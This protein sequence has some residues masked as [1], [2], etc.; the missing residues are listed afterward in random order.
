MRKDLLDIDRNDPLK[1]EYLINPER[2]DK[3]QRIKATF[4]KILSDAGVTVTDKDDTELSCHFGLDK[5]QINY[6][7]NVKN[8]RWITIIKT[9]P[10]VLISEKEAIVLNTITKDN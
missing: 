7:K 8:S 1:K 9:Y 2:E 4:N 5:F 6:I 10:S 3:L